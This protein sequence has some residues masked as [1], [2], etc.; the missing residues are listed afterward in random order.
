LNFNK[1]ADEGLGTTSFLLHT[2]DLKEADKI[3][4]RHFA[5]PKPAREVSLIFPK[6]IEKHN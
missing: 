5:E 4:L 2:L 6:G 1:L 3:K